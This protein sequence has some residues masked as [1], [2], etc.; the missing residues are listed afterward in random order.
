MKDVPAGLQAYLNTGTTTLCYCWRVERRDGVVQGFTEHDVDLIFGGVTYKASAG[1][2]ASHV[3]QNLGVSVDNLNVDGA[4]SDASLNEADLAAGHYDSAE[5]SLFWVNWRDT[6]ERVLI[7][8]GLLGEVKRSGIAFSAELRG[9]TSRLGQSTGRT[10]QRTCDAVVGDARCGVNLAVAQ[11]RGLGT[12]DEVSSERLFNV[13]GLN[14]FADDW[15]SAG[16]LTFTSGD[17]HGQGIEVK[18]HNRRA[19][20]ATI[21]LWTPPAFP[22]VAGD[23][24]R[25][26]AGCKQT[27]D[28]CK[29][30][31]NNVENFRGF[32]LMPGSD[33]ILFYPVR[34][35]GNQ[36]GES[37]FAK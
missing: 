12:V 4:L 2:T 36:D 17:N 26:T 18:T 15:F 34:G 28:V 24:F 19:S 20:I 21:E 3:V 13:T 1:F 5:V 27:I 22:V 30:K 32:N 35:A 14:G 23:D 16:Y 6:S 10:Y 29:A 11:Y 33:A 31:F 37:L 8:R 25:I 7:N 9:L